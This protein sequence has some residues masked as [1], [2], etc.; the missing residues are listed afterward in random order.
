ML[1]NIAV[2]L[3]KG[4]FGWWVGA[5][6]IAADGVHSLIDAAANVVGLFVLGWSTRPPDDSHPY[7]HGKMEV[8]AAAAIGIAVGS[9][10]IRFGWEAVDAL[11]FGRKPPAS[12]VAGFAI[13]GGTW[14]VN[15]GVAWWEARKA[16]ELDSTYLAADAAHTAS[17]VVV[18]AAV[19]TSYTASYFGIEWADPIGALLVL[20]V[21]G[22]VAWLILSRNLSV[23]VD[24][25]AVEPVK[26]VEIARTVPGVRGV[27][28][29][30]SR[31]P[32]AA[33]IV[34]LHILLDNHL[35]LREAH[36][37]AHDVEKALLE[38][39]AD[40][41]DVTVHMEPEEDGYETL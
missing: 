24:A 32:R 13:I 11:M 34:D 25:V 27:H 18:T 37:I 1:L 22:R 19:L 2:A 7:G 23:L 39:I 29:V 14:L 9:A 8:A 30:R 33:A 12:T 10:A 21:I 36:A 38:S 5:L 16:R 28:R 40:V 26:V 41:V 15:M 20:V 35:T 17:D 31:G 4:I 6:A 3:A